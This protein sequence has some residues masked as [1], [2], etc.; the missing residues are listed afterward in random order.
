MKLRS[1]RYVSFLF[2]AVALVG[3][4]GGDGSVKTPE[5]AKPAPTT[6]GTEDSKTAKI[7]AAD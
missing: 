5:N 3:C 2:V 1:L 7:E 6:K 4:G